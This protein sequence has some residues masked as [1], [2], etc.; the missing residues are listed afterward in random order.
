MLFDEVAGLY[1]ATR[2]GYP[3]ELVDAVVDDAAIGPG[4]AVLEIGC[5]TGQ[6]TRQLAGRGFDLTA[7]DIGAAMV[8]AARGNVADEA[9]RFEVCSFE[10]FAG[11]GPFDLIVSATAFHW[12][13]PGVGLAK[14]A[15]LLR[16]GGWLALLTTGERYPEQ[17]W[18]GM[19]ELWVRYSRQTGEWAD[20]PSWLAA[21]RDSELFGATVEAGH[22]TALRLPAETVLGVER[23]RATF[24]SFTEQDQADFTRELTALLEPGSHIDVVQ[25]SFLAMAPTS[26][27]SD[28]QGSDEQR[29]HLTP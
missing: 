24:L 14:A 5:G 23:T 11:G 3:R 26:R 12:I 10:D 4:A 28:E 16:P 29:L 27:R 15:R 19:R 21:L 9:A 20:Q 6:L 13:D 22:A 17:L 25:E 1:D 2:Q 8:E 18:G 7:I